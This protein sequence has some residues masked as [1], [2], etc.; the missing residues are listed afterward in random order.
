MLWTK[1]WGVFAGTSIV[2]TVPQFKKV[3]V[4]R[5]SGQKK[6]PSKIPRSISGVRAASVPG[7]APNSYW[8]PFS[9]KLPKMVSARNTL[10]VSHSEMFFSQRVATT[11]FDLTT[12]AINPGNPAVFPWLSPIALR[13]ETYKFRSL[14]FV[15]HTRCVYTNYG[16]VG[17]Y[18]DHD[19]NDPDPASYFEACQMQG[20]V[21]TSIYMP[22]THSVD[23][24]S[25]TVKA[26]YVR[27]G[28]PD[29]SFDQKQYDVGKWVAYSDLT[30][31]VGAICGYWSVEY[32]VELI[33][34]QN[35][36]PASGQWINMGAQHPNIVN[37][38]VA[39][40][41]SRR[42]FVTTGGQTL[43]FIEPFEGLMQIGASSPSVNRNITASS[44]DGGLLHLVENCFLEQSKQIA[45]Y[46]IKMATGQTVRFQD[47]MID[48]TTF[49]IC[50]AKAAYDSFL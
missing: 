23:V 2:V 30:N 12:F 15:Y 49:G 31:V 50:L 3:V 25:D 33:T 44:V 9:S 36:D 40:G 27:D 4:R 42:P 1:P 20:N 22:L 10:N 18:F 35:Q 17:A 37:D 43:T 14:R 7:S 8:T 11:G 26:R 45:V 39:V 48:I 38:L 47:Y 6:K 32:D 46:A 29:G 41:H 5:P 24:G 21:S 13:Y 28:V 34:P 16:V 19:P